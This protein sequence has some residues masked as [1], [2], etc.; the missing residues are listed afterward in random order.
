MRYRL[1]LVFSV[2]MMAASAVH[3]QTTQP[4]SPSPVADGSK[5]VSESGGTALEVAAQEWLGRAESGDL[6]PAWNVKEPPTGIPPAYDVAPAVVKEARTRCRFHSEKERRALLLC[7]QIFGA[8]TREDTPRVGAR[9]TP[10]PVP[11]PPV[12]Q[13]PNAQIDV[14]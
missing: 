6:I 9:S 14:R 8:Y 2:V 4:A 11:P 5:R 3:G 1:A 10:P 13:P 12:W 7:L